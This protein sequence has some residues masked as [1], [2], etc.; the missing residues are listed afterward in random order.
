[1]LCQTLKHPEVICTSSNA[2][3]WAYCQGTVSPLNPLSLIPAGLGSVPSYPLHGCKDLDG[4]I[5]SGHGSYL[6]G[7]RDADKE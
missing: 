6:G 7:G 5:G 3:H 2:R 4:V 1:M